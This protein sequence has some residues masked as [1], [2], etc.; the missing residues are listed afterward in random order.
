MTRR[1][2]SFYTTENLSEE[3]KVAAQREGVSQ[4]EIINR[5]L[6]QYFSTKIVR[7]SWDTDDEGS[8]YDERKFYTYSEDKKG[9]SIQIRLWVPKNVAGQIGRVI[10]S[11][12][13]PEYRSSQDFYRDALLHRAF[14]V[15]QWIDDGELQAEVGLAMMLAEEDAIKQMKAD[16]EALVESTRENLTAAWERGD[17]DWIEKHVNER[18]EK[19]TSVPENLRDDYVR[20]LKGFKDRLEE[21]RKGKVRHIKTLPEAAN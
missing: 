16:V 4:S 6:G 5:A 21:V 2:Q 10:N 18:L 7:S 19:S 11:D 3:I 17:Y 12:Q 15:A 20:L 1:S 9:H 14:R 8:W 13:I